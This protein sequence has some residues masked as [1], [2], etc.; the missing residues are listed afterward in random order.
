MDQRKVAFPPRL[1]VILASVK[2]VGVVFRR[3]PSKEVATFLWD[4]KTDEFSLGQW[5]KGRIY[6]RRADIS[7]DGDKMIYFAMNG[8]WD[9]EARGSWTAVSKVPF[10]KALDLHAKGDCW[11]G[12]GLFLNDQSYWLNDRY[13]DE[14]Y[15]L[16]SL[17]GLACDSSAR[18]EQHFGSECTGVYYPRLLRD[19]WQ[20]VEKSGPHLD[21]QTIFEKPLAHSWTL[22]KV[23]HEQIDAPVGKGVYWD[24]HEIINKHTGARQRFPDWEWAEWEQES[25]VWAELGKLYRARIVSEAVLGEAKL[26]HDFKDYHFE[27]LVAP[28]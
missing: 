26:L 20:L 27:P 15:T 3:G 2:S 25:L 6:E 16:K 17:S 19:G 1:H 18:P 9:S 7:P 14:R 28:Y 10:L 8:K 4:R 22:R 24:E 5:L 13:F 12:G 11:E 23:A 21:S